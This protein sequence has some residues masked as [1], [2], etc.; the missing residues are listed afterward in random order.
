ML[1]RTDR[2]LGQGAGVGGW[3]GRREEG[4][5]NGMVRHA[6]VWGQFHSLSITDPYVLALPQVIWTVMCCEVT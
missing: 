4:L 2:W 3:E 6:T 5:G 1:G